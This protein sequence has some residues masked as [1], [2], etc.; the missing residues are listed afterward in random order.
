[1]IVASYGVAVVSITALALLMGEL[2][3][4]QA[5][6]GLVGARLADTLA[7]CGLTA[8]PDLKAR[9]R[10]LAH[11]L[12][13]LAAIQRDAVADAHPRTDGRRLLTRAIERLA[14]AALSAPPA[15]DDAA[16]LAAA[17]DALAA[18]AATGAP[19]R[20]TL[21][22]LPAL[23]RTRAALTQLAAALAATGPPDDRRAAKR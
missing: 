16:A 8:A 17:T 11:V 20:P 23:P 2:A 3:H 19:A 12:A 7:G 10:T 18:Q 14:F 5:G 1:V 22:P 6:A 15:T 21:P 4:P 9:R 13:D